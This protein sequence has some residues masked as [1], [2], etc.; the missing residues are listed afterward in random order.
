[1]RHEFVIENSIPSHVFK[2]YF[3]IKYLMNCKFLSIYK[4]CSNCDL[5][6]IN[7]DIE[8]TSGYS[9]FYLNGIEIYKRL[10]SELE[11]PISCDEFIIKN[12]IE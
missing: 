10:T 3:N 9:I 5:E 8:S 11:L 7:V 12:I 6:V 2:K 1:M 4:K